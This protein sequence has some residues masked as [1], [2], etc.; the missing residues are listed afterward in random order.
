MKRSLSPWRSSVEIEERF[1]ASLN[2]D[3]AESYRSCIIRYDVPGSVGWKTPEGERAG[4]IETVVR[5]IIA[6]HDA[7]QPAIEDVA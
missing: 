4:G 1:G 2:W 5:H 7:F 3:K 6:L